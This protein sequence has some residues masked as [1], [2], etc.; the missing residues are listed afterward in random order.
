MTAE[1]VVPLAV[2]VI[3]A[4]PAV[5]ATVLSVRNVGRQNDA[6]HGRVRDRLDELTA[7]VASAEASNVAAHERL[8]NEVSRVAGRFEAHAADDEDLHRRLGDW[9]DS[10]GA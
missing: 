3:A 6:D 4:F 1:V 9:L 5:L 10:Q 7:T 2:A 8:T